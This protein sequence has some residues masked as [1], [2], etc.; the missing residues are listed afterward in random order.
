[1][2]APF[3]SEPVV[4]GVARTTL[5]RQLSTYTRP[6]KTT[7]PPLNS[8]LLFLNRCAAFESTIDLLN[9]K[10]YTATVVGARRTSVLL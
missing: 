2:S 5:T 9:T 6:R 3:I 4:A 8:P 10:N 1:V 7:I